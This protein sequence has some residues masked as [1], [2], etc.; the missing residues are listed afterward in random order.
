MQHLKSNRYPLNPELANTLHTNHA[1]SRSTA[2]PGLPCTTAAGKSKGRKGRKTGRKGRGGG[3]E[4][5]EKERKERDERVK[6]RKQK[7]DEK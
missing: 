3:E 2:C 4:K 6:K 5:R 1:P 7:K